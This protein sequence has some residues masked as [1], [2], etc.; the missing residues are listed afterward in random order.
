MA[1]SL[2]HTLL[3]LFVTIRVIDPEYY[4]LYQFVFHLCEF[5]LSSI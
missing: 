3:L 2:N 5:E 1:H 4:V